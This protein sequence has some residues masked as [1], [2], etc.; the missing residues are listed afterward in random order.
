MREAD[1]AAVG[2]VAAAVHP[3][4]PEDQH[5]FAERLALH[6]AGCRL[7]ARSGEAAG[8]AISHPW[9]FGTFPALNSLI[10]AIPADADAYYIH[11]LALLPSARG[12][13][14]AGAVVADIKAH[15]A[16]LG[17]SRLS[18]VAVGGSAGF[19][20]GQGFAAVDRPDAGRKL[21][22]YGPGACL[23]ACTIA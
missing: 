6:P 7:L 19:W 5:V 20:Q 18:L 12:A 15:A 21:A 11:D 2:A 4:L 13:G 23:M 10:G 8:Y 1:L 9:R 3:A 17:L 22:A 16:G 14:A